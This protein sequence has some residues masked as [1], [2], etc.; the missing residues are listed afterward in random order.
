MNICHNP[1]TPEFKALMKVYNNEDLVQVLINLYN[2]N[3]D[4]A[5]ITIPTTLQVADMLLKQKKAFNT[6]KKDFAEKIMLNLQSMDYVTKVKGEWIVKKQISNLDSTDT[7][8]IINQ[9][10][11]VAYLTYLGFNSNGIKFNQNGAVTQIKINPNAITYKNMNPIEGSRY[12]ISIINHFSNVFPQ[13]K[14]KTI[15]PSEAEV[16]YNEAAKLSELKVDFANVKSFYANGVAYLINGRFSDK[17]AIEE[18][19]HPFV[20]ALYSDNNELFQ[21]LYNEAELS[22][23]SIVDSVNNAYNSTKNFDIK[24]RQLEVVTKALTEHIN[25][26]YEQQVPLESFVDRV[27]EF[28]KWFASILNK[29]LSAIT[30]GKL[31]VS[32]SEIEK[33]TSLTEIVDM[34]LTKNVSFNFDIVPTDIRLSIE[35][36]LRPAV[37]KIRARANET[38]RKIIDDIVLNDPQKLILMKDIIV[39]GVKRKHVYLSESTD[40]IYTSTTTAIKGPM[41]AEDEERNALSLLLGNQVDAVLEGIAAGSDY[42]TV[43]SEIQKS[44][45]SINME[46]FAKQGKPMLSGI[47]EDLLGNIYNT[48]NELVNNPE[49][50]SDDAIIIPQIIIGDP[51]SGIAGSLDLLIINGDGSLEIID[52]KTSINS[53]NRTETDSDGTT[54]YPYSDK[55]YPVKEG[56]LLGIDTELSTKAQQGIQVSVYRRILENMNYTVNAVKTIHILLKLDNKKVV[57]YEYE[58]SVEHSVTDNN[59][60]VDK[61]VP[62]NDSPGDRANNSFIRKKEF[63]SEEDKLSLEENQE[64]DNIK[65]LPILT[66]IKAKLFTR[67]QMVDRL[68]TEAKGFKNRVEL[69]NKLSLLITSMEEDINETQYNAALGKLLRYTEEDIQNFLKYLDNPSSFKSASFPTILLNYDKF[70]ETYTG[71]EIAIDYANAGNQVTGMKVKELIREAKQRLQ[72]GYLDYAESFVKENSSNPDLTEEDIK[73]MLKSTVDEQFF[74]SALSSLGASSDTLL[75]LINKIYKQ[76]F[77]QAQYEADDFVQTVNDVANP[78]IQASLDKGIKPEDVYLFM[79]ARNPNGKL[80]GR[81]VN[82]IGYQYWEEYYKLK[83]KTQGVNGEPLN[84]RLITNPEKQREDIQYNIQL[85]KDKK[86]FREFLSAEESVDDV[87]VDGKYHKLTEEYKRERSKYQV[88]T[89]WG[90]KRRAGVDLL[91]YSLFNEKYNNKISYKKPVIGPDGMFTGEMKD[92]TYHIPKREYTE[93]RDFSSDGKDMR[94]PEYVNIMNPK[95]A[96][97]VARKNFYEFFIKEHQTGSLGMLPKD[98]YYQMMGKMPR[99]SKNYF[100]KIKDMP[101][102]RGKFLL[103]N[104]KNF[105]FKKS[106]VYARTA[107]ENEDGT[108]VQGP[109]IFYTADLKSQFKMDRLNKQIEELRKKREDKKIN[110]KDYLAEKEKLDRMLKAEESKLTA[111]DISTDVAQNMILFRTM[112]NNYQKMNQIEDTIM[113][114]QKIIEDREY[115]PPGSL[116]SKIKTSV[117]ITKPYAVRGG[118]NVEKRLKKWLE[119]VFRNESAFEEGVLQQYVNTILNYTSLTYVGFNIFSSLNNLIMGKINNGIESAGGQFYNKKAIIR[120]TKELNSDALPG[121]MRQLSKEAPGKVASMFNKKGERSIPKPESK[122]EAMVDYFKVIR[123]MQSTEGRPNILGFAYWMQEGGE[124]MVQSKTG[125]AKLMSVQLLNKKT[126]ETTSVYDAFVF[127]PSTGALDLKDG[128]ELS[129]KERADITN[130]IWRMNEMIHGNYAY[131]DRIT[132]QNHWLG[133]LALQFHKWV[134]P[135]L[136]IRF[137]KGRYDEATQVWMEG[138][139]NTIWNFIKYMYFVQG[140]I[141]EKFK[142]AKGELRSEQIANLYKILAEIAFFLS[143]VAM[144]QI[145]EALKDGT[146]DDEKELRRLLGALQYQGSKQQKELLTFVSP[147]EYVR[148]VTNPIA[149]SRSLREFSEALGFT[150]EYFS[151]LVPE[152]QKYYQ[153]TDRKGEPKYYKQWGDVAP[154]LYEI[155]RW[156]SYD[157]VE[158]FYVR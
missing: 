155:N 132:I 69:I 7:S 78:L 5:D 35:K 110:L 74:D 9:N 11:I 158:D 126:G 101:E 86:A 40:Q 114:I 82:R 68:Y 25:K 38:Q 88:Y 106:K 142:E 80:N 19:M 72:K 22:Y 55:K 125:V 61:I 147:E 41:S 122:Y 153:R 81:Y 152:E 136:K 113:I 28:F 30:A 23:P 98:I 140:N 8:D 73:E 32:P 129:E 77:I 107:I 137:G 10:A 18:I 99:I 149:A 2:E 42:K 102:G 26:R 56:S 92:V 105:V 3:I 67:K 14:I 65:L 27:Q 60:Y 34:V 103:N 76:K 58:G 85:Y 48:L 39:N 12:T 148:I 134:W 53:I 36:G 117:G 83:E 15:D 97:G 96:L 108:L 93:I 62:S 150:V 94:D 143:S 133:M 66:D 139:Y 138:R 6:Q 75:Q 70:L 128:Y 154:I 87:P 111:D 119:M 127:N 121:F 131:E 115:S 24:T 29:V 91:S 57:G 90:W 33:A 95:D 45:V 1:N 20:D 51:N 145:F 49:F 144:Y 109:P 37:E 4:S 52:L 156:K 50:I 71:I 84:Y 116:S 130:S 141:I 89:K 54:I 21:N 112:A 46:R 16:I 31:T 79:Y 13:I 100:N 43:L 59:Y 151:P 63:L 124:Y 135:A 157:T 17:T 44:T 146:D 47:S 120:A 104:I 123:G 118:S 64:V